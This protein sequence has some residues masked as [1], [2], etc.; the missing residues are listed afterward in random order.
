MKDSKANPFA[1][2]LN[3]ARKITAFRSKALSIS[4]LNQ[5]VTSGTNF[6]LGL[7]L[8]RTLSPNDFGLYG[9]GFAVVLLYSG[10]GNALFLTQMVVHVPDKAPPERLL[11][12]SRILATLFIFCLTTIFIIGLFV[13]SS[14]HS[15]NSYWQYSEL[16]LSITAA[17]TTY[18]LKDFFVRHAYTIR[19]EILA[20]IISTTISV[21]L[22]ITLFVL[23]QVNMALH[24][25]TVLF[26]YATGN[27]VGAIVG[28]L[29]TRLPLLN[30]RLAEVI[31]DSREAWIGGRWALGGVSVSWLQGQAYMYVTAIFIGPAGVGYANAAKIFITPA[32][33]MMPAISQVI[34]PNLAR[35]RASD[36]KKMLSV[37]RMLFLVAI[38]FAVIY[39]TIL[40]IGLDYLTPMLVSSKYK[41]IGLL[42]A[43]WC[44]ALTCQF[45][46]ASSNVF[47]QAS[48][49]FKIL[50]FANTISFIVAIIT[51]VILMQLFG[52]YGAIIGTASGDAIMSILLFFYIRLNFSEKSSA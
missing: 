7:Y 5:I 35:L 28:V 50:T 13:L 20:L 21:T 15:L 39:S 30:I 8:I 31:K 43:A 12:A 18:L 52:V 9:I 26:A 48:K 44:L 25:S 23:N 19:K 29:L 33:V 6:F 37:Y 47:L 45:S 38:G 24:S 2:L 22:G 41:S 16:L 17:S 42:V 32:Q 4:I 1:T 40:L 14:R 51:T 49:E 10:I 11:Y 46:N 3:V 27:M 34:M 36:P